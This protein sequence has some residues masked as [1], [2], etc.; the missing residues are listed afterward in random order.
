MTKSMVIGP[1]Q[2]ICAAFAFKTEDLALTKCVCG[3]TPARTG[4]KPAVIA[5][6]RRW[7]PGGPPGGR[8]GGPDRW[9]MRHA[10]SV[11]EASLLRLM[12]ESPRFPCGL[13]DTE[14]NRMVRTRSQQQRLRRG[15][16]AA[17]NASS[18]T[19][20]TLRLT[21]AVVAAA[22]L[23]V[24][25][26]VPRAQGFKAPMMRMSAGQQNRR[27]VSA[28]CVGRCCLSG[29]ENMTKHSSSVPLRAP[30]HVGP[31]GHRQGPT[32]SGDRCLLE[33]QLEHKN[34]ETRATTYLLMAR[35][36][37]VWV[38]TVPTL[39]PQAPW[40]PAS[41][42]WASRH[43]PSRLSSRA[44]RRRPTCARPRQAGSPKRPT[45]RTP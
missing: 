32:G 45:W 39:H 41:W 16:K 40:R 25:F 9:A 23:L 4:S 10:P 13:H 29:R 3:R 12:R 38:R 2:S 44:T 37:L 22:L 7:R 15:E 21:A 27:C 24:L 28:L 8:W 17:A 11:I 33:V 26:L 30:P 31:P 43:P 19:V 6:R 18:A 5:P 1:P 35:A 14:M 42:G 34:R 36:H 20:G